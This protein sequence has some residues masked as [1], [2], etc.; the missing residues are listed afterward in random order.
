MSYSGMVDEYTLKKNS[1]AIV[2]FEPIYWV[3]LYWLLYVS[4]TTHCLMCSIILCLYLTI[5]I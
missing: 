5:A 4:S 3:Y 1:E 2:Y